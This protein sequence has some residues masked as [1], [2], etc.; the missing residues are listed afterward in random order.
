MKNHKS[1][2]LI[3]ALIVGLGTLSS[4]KK[5]KVTEK[6]AIEF[7]YIKQGKDKP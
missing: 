7:T 3:F 5:T 2:V 6:D 4:C 1:I